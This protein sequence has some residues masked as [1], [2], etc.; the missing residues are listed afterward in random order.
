MEGPYWQKEGLLQQTM[1]LLQGPKD[2][3]LPTLMKMPKFLKK[4]VESLKK[5]GGKET[6]KIHTAM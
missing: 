3:F 1:T 5:S 4:G 2:P 6:E